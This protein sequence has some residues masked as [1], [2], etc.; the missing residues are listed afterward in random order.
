MSAGG[1]QR[2]L[3]KQAALNVLRP[4]RC[5]IPVSSNVGQKRLGNRKCT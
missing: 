4:V 5:R 2:I 3:D 1:L